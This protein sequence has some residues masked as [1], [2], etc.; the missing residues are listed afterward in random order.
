MRRCRRRPG[1]RSE[2]SRGATPL[3]ACVSG[4]APR[5]RATGGAD[6]AH[7]RGQPRPRAPPARR[8]GGDR[9][10]RVEQQGRRAR[11]FVLELDPRRVG[12]PW[13]AAGGQGSDP[14]RSLAPGGRPAGRRAK[15]ARSRLAPP[16]APA[17]SR[18]GA[19]RCWRSARPR[20][21][22]REP[23]WSGCSPS[24]VFDRALFG[25][26]DRT[27]LDAFRSL[28][29][30]AN[31]AGPAHRCMH[32]DRA[33]PRLRRSWRSTPTPWSLAPRSSWRC[34]GRWRRTSRD[35]AGR[36]LMLFVDLLRLTV[37][38]IGGVGDG[39]RHRHNA[40]GEA[41]RRRHHPDRRWGWW[42]V[43]AGL[44]IYL[45]GSARAGEAMSRVLAGART[46][47]VA[48]DREPGTDRLPAAVADRR[49]RVDRRAGSPGCCP[50]WPP[51]APA[52]RSS[53]RSPGETASGP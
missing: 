19:G 35:G 44:G 11:E 45:G 1:T 3:V 10:G 7:L 27:D 8:A 25:G 17:W 23:R 46:A 39:A 43:A 51:S 48:A 30:L 15:G 33:P 42:V 41:G 24:R 52:S 22:T 31:R 20:E 21:S 4:R 2:S 12:G 18:M 49:L 34:S 32:R 5:R 9:L 40:G 36:G 6:R 14:G 29:A 26:D 16:N 13:A 38:L 53:T 50:R 37:L 47:T 28:R